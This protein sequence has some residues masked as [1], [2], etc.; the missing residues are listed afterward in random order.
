[1]QILFKLK[2]FGIL[3]FCRDNLKCAALNKTFHRIIVGEQLFP[4]C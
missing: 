2:A 4:R 3:Q 1:M